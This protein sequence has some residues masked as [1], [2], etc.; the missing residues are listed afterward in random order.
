MIKATSTR[1]S[2][3]S[4]LVALALPGLFSGCDT[5]AYQRRSLID[6]QATGTG[7]TIGTNSFYITVE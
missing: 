6:E 4:L 2:L 1:S 3:V 5:G 7:G